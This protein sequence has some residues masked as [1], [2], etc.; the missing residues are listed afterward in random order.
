[1]RWRENVSGRKI[2]KEN[3]EGGKTFTI[4][5]L[6]EKGTLSDTDMCT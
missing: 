3:G 4:K 5:R 1:M 6:S 2:E